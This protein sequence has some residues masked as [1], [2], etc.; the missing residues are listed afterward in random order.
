MSFI[1]YLETMDQKIILLLN[2]NNYALLDQL[3][4]TVSKPVFGLPR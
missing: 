4:W 2:G 1:N 3:R